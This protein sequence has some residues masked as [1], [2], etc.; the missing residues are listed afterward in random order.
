MNKNNIL[1]T[2]NNSA[3]I[4]KLLKINTLAMGGGGMLGFYY[5][6]CLQYIEDIGLLKKI[7]TFYCCSVGAFICSLVAIGY[8]TSEIIE[9][10]SNF[11]FELLSNKKNFESMLDKNKFFILLKQLIK[12]KVN[13]KITLKQLAINNN[14]FIHLTAY[15]L[16]QRKQ[17]IL[18]HV[19]YPNMKLVEAI[20]ISCALPI[21]LFP[22][23]YNNEWLCDNGINNI[24]PICFIPREQQ[25]NTIGI[26]G[27]S[28][29]E[30]SS[31]EYKIRID[32]MLS[33]K[34][35]INNIQL[36]I[37][38]LTIIAKKPYIDPAN[39]NILKINNKGIDDCLDFK[40]NLEQKKERIKQ[41]YDEGKKLLPSLFKYYLSK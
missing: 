31:E 11:D 39:N 20:Y 33:N 32:N 1:E 37:E 22:M 23:K 14:K 40:L 41:G 35:I 6:G 34:T 29:G 5:I 2:I 18:N 21:L 16:T 12:R 4:A 24:N 30:D 3:N 36:L 25:K 17:I 8:S 38:V 13:K 7:N 9:F 27:T 10:S 15:N 19:T 28:Y 26:T